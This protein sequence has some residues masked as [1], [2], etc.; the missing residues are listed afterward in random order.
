[1]EEKKRT[2][3]PGDEEKYCLW[4]ANQR[5]WKPQKLEEIKQKR[6]TGGKEK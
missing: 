1:M 5:K 2:H 4:W 6:L 3:F